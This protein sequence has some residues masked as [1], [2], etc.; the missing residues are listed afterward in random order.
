M[1]LERETFCQDISDH[2]STHGSKLSNLTKRCSKLKQ[3][4]ALCTMLGWAALSLQWS[5][6]RAAGTLEKSS[7]VGAKDCPTQMHARMS[8]ELSAISVYMRSL[9]VYPYAKDASQAAVRCRPLCA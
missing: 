5:I 1:K 9:M 8:H 3:G 2:G 6:P 7:R 4:M